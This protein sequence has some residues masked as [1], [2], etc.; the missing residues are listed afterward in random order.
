MVL[1]GIVLFVVFAT[2]CTNTYSIQKQEIIR[3]L[4][5]TVTGESVSKGEF[6]LLTSM[7]VIVDDYG[8]IRAT[9]VR[10]ATMSDE[11]LEEAVTAAS[12]SEEDMGKLEKQ[13]L[14]F[15]KTDI[16]GGEAIVFVD[17]SRMDR[18]VQRTI[19]LSFVVYLLSMVLVYFISRLV[20]SIAIEPV[21][22]S[23]EQ[24]KQ[25]VAD[26]SHELKTPLTV[27]LANSDILKRRGN[28]TIAEERQWIDSTVE[29]ASHMKSLVEDML[30]LARNDSG[31]VAYEMEEINLSDLVE[32]NILQVEALAYEGGVIMESNVE[33]D[34]VISGNRKEL[35]QL[36]HIL[37]DNAIKYAGAPAEGEEIAIRVELKKDAKGSC[38]LEVRNTGAVLPE[39]DIAHMF[40]R[41]YRGDKARTRGETGGYGL[42]LA[43][44]KTIVENHGGRIQAAS[45]PDCGPGGMQGTAFR[46]DRFHTV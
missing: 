25:F 22:N 32:E 18:A 19:L 27:I 15:E 13:D 46:A 45:G 36:M 9:Y 5:A 38:V 40:D 24:Q 7:V 14:Y 2:I 39:E 33:K 43:I 30:Y 44:A 28:S 35:R 34:I 23:W 4:R 31:T 16:S 1:V 26:A 37:L 20:A 11:K 42:G 10:G 29:E 8:N 41:F 6:G 21:K 17:S 3:T 12:G